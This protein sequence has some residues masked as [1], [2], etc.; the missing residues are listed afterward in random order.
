VRY[1]DA[2]ASATFVLEPGEDVASDDTPIRL[3]VEIID[4]LTNQPLGGKT[5]VQIRFKGKIV[6]IEDTNDVGEARIEIKDSEALPLS[7]LRTGLKVDAYHDNFVPR[8]SDIASSE[9]LPSRVPR[10]VTLHLER[11]W[12]QLRKSL[13]TLEGKVAAWNNDVLLVSEKAASVIKLVKETASAESQAIKIGEGLGGGFSS[14]N[15]AGGRPS[16][17]AICRKAGEL[18]QNIQQYETEALSKERSLKQLLDRAEVAAANCKS[19]QQAEAVKRDYNAAVR[20]SGEIGALVNQ[21]RTANEQLS[22]VAA[23]LKE[24]PN[25]SDVESKLAEIVKLSLAA[26]QAAINAEVDTRRAEGLSKQ[27]SGRRD[28]LTGEIVELKTRSGINKSGTGLPPDLKQ[29]VDTIESLLGSR[30][31]DV[32]AGPDPNAQA[33]V[34]ASAEKIREIKAS[35][36]VAVFSLKN[37]EAQCEVAPMNEAFERMGN[38]ITSASVE[39]YAA[40]NLRIK[41]K[42]CAERGACQPLLGDVRGLLENDDLETAAARIS[43][44]RAQGCDVSEPEKELEYW[45]TVRQTANLIAS[46]V[47]SCRFQEA[48]NIGERIPAGI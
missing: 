5:N 47:D 12:T 22:T 9:L 18:K 32:M 40:A 20:L 16:V 23:M 43:A 15:I 42:E 35:A 30:N 33:L 45:S 2:G 34:K 4:S 31:N 10:I 37:S 29:R 8:D 21:A 13:A 41:A 24:R 44:A 3:V 1:N 36:E 11:D 25:I 28:A 6:A 19:A 14:D 7:E 26:D 46:S 27:L 48:L 17:A 38:A 39:L